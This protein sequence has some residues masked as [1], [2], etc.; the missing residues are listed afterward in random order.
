MSRL[1]ILLAD[2]H[3]AFRCSLSSFLQSQSGVEV[4]GEARDGVEA[5]DQTQKLRPDLV[6][7]D[8]QMPNRDGCVATREIK[9]HSPET[10]VVILSVY[11]DEMYRRQAWLHAADG[12][13]DKSAMKNA[14]KAF[15]AS[16]LTRRETQPVNIDAA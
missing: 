12:F 10:K 2:D 7:M 16:E 9:Q 11:G 3:E 5:V 4:V 1:R 15:L 6:L 13:I 8:L 14:L